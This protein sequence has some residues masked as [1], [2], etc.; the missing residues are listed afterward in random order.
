VA[1][2]QQGQKK[3]AAKAKLLA[4]LM[5][6]AGESRQ[7]FKLMM[8]VKAF[9]V[10]NSLPMSASM[11]CAV[12]NVVA[13]RDRIVPEERQLWPLLW[14]PGEP[15]AMTWRLYAFL[16][17]SAVRQLLFGLRTPE[18]THNICGAISFEMV[19]AAISCEQVVDLMQGSAAAGG[20]VAGGT[21]VSGARCRFNRS[22]S[23]SIR[24]S[25]GR[26][27]KGSVRTSIKSFKS[28]KGIKRSDSNAS[29]SSDVSSDSSGSSD[30]CVSASSEV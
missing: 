2:L 10:Q 18:N 22:I 30:S 15:G 8:G 23:T 25:I 13:L 1:S 11:V 17:Q 20:G 27:V 3:A 4:S 6:L 9:A 29:I 12:D 16:F 7:A 5:R 28:I 21:F 24:R 19:P 14:A 26:S